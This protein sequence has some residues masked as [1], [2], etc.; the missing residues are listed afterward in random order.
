MLSFDFY[1][2]GR[3]ETTIVTFPDNSIGIIDAH[4]SSNGNRPNILSLIQD[5]T[6]RFICLT[7]PHDDHYLDLPAVFSQNPP[8]EFWHTI[9]D[10]KAFFYSL[11][12]YNEFNAQTDSL[13]AKLLTRRAEPLINI[14]FKCKQDKIEQLNLTDKLAPIDICNVK[15][16]ILAPQNSTI[17]NYKYELA[18]HANNRRK[19][20]PDPNDISAALAFEYA[21]KTFIHG[22]DV[23]AKQWHGIISRA[24]NQN[25]PAAS[26]FKVPHHGAKNA[27]DMVHTSEN[28]M[29]LFANEVSTITFGN[30]TH[31]DIDVFRLLNSKSK[32]MYFLINKFAL[33][34]PLNI[35]DACCQSQPHICNSIV[36]VEINNEGMI[37]ITLGK[38]CR[39]CNQL[40][41]CLE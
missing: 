27:L 9:P 22:G 25:F 38:G 33:A 23:L 36:R 35:P 12:Q 31:P 3:G 15:I 17:S 16:T 8:L 26:I 1:E 28:Y 10:V 41:S 29:Q 30:S 18:N 37:S 11:G 13:M 40:P 32:D 20:M 7:H 5:K 4:P 19:D 2:S 14:F 6:I 21:G 39:S 24:Q 34:N